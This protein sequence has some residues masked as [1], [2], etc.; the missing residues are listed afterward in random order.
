MYRLLPDKRNA[1]FKPVL[2]L[3]KFSCST[4]HECLAYSE[5]LA[6]FPL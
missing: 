5:F 4:G 1:L 6:D 2:S 3:S